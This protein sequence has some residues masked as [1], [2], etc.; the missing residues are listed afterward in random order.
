MP[1]TC[2]ADEKF[3]KTWSDTVWHYY[4]WSYHRQVEMVDA[5]IGRIL[6]AL[7]NSPHADNTLIVFTSD[8]GDGMAH[9]RLF[10]KLSFYDGSLRVPLIVSWPGQ[11]AENHVDRTHLA[12][13]FDLTPTL[14]DYAG[15]APPPE[16]RGLSLRPVIKGRNPSW[17]DYVVA[18]NYVIGRMVPAPL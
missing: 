1:L 3:C 2:R 12:S 15:T 10:H 4:V 9:H 6:D 7:E 16:Q 14:C 11:V 13:G 18:H 5:S 17:R 8:H